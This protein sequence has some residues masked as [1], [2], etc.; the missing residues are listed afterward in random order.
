MTARRIDLDQRRQEAHREPV[1]VVVGGRTFSLLPTLPVSLALQVDQLAG[2]DLD[3]ARIE[4]VFRTLM[5]GLAGDQAEELA[6]LISLDELQALMV[7]AYGM[8]MGESEASAGSSPNGG[9]P[10]RPT[11]PATTTET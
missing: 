7:E 5:H 8:T 11:V 10:P 9:T 4:T 3:P 2:G 6:G 1:E